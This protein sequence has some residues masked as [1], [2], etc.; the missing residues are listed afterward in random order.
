MLSDAVRFRRVSLGKRTRHSG[1]PFVG[2]LYDPDFMPEGPRPALAKP[3][4]LPANLY[5]RRRFQTESERQEH[6]LGHYEQMQAPIAVEAAP[7]L[8]RRRRWRPATRR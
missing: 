1:R 2:R 5:C 4:T 8:G 7:G 6:F 3:S